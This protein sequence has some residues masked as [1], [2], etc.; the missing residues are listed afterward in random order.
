MSCD[1]NENEIMNLLWTSWRMLQSEHVDSV[2]DS[3]SVFSFHLEELSSFQKHTFS[4][5]CAGKTPQLKWR[6]LMT[7]TWGWGIRTE[8]CHGHLKCEEAD[9]QNQDPVPMTYLTEKQLWRWSICFRY[10]Y[11]LHSMTMWNS[12][13]FEK[14]P[15]CVV[16]SFKD[17]YYIL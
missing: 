5:T 16:I 15:L 13:S 14:I 10:F 9:F 17:W 6:P 3:S 12:L 4:C 2:K 1:L 8:M 11:I 7:E